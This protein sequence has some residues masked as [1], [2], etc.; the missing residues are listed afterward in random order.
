MTGMTGTTGCL[1]CG[2]SVTTTL[3]RLAALLFLTLNPAAAMARAALTLPYEVSDLWAT[4]VRFVRVDRGYA[5]REKDETAGYIL[6]D[7][8]D[9][10]RSYRAALELVPTTDTDGRPSTQAVVS[11]PDLP[12]HYET[13]LL[14]RLATK[15]REERVIRGTA[16]PVRR[17]PPAGDPPEKDRDR[18]R[19][20]DKRP[21]PPDGGLP[22]APGAESS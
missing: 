8:L 11:I 1:G 9:G 4:A 15:A 12:R 21:P 20:K 13:A 10:A 18:D 2:R 5:I 14:D 22:R 7:Y 3:I 16:P 17:R 19:D 6:F